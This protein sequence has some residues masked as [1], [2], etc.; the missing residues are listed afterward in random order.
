MRSAR[1]VLLLAALACTDPGDAPWGFD[2]RPEQGFRLE[3]QDETTIDDV[4]V[5]IERL[6]DV[7]L[8]ANADAAGFEIDLLLDRFYLEVDG[9]PGGS[10]EVAISPKAFVSRAADGTELRLEAAERTPSARSVAEL[11]GAPIGGTI[12]DASGAA[13]SSSW[14]SADPLLSE[15]EVLGW[16]LLGLPVAGGAETAWN[17]SREVP[18]IGRYRFGIEMPLRFERVAGGSEVAFSGFVERPDIT[19]ADGYRGAIELEVEGSARLAADGSVAGSRYLLRM[20]FEP[21]DGGVIRSRH[22]VVIGCLG[23]E[24]DG[25]QISP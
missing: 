8:R 10:T 7:R 25:V 16:L 11:L 14:H 15:V 5:D 4:V 19:L 21:V 13:Q 22:R 6:A 17:A 3:M 2:V 23:C 18:R 9:G 1:A 24:G 20:K 12:V